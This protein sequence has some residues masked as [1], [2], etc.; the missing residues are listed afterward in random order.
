MNIDINGRNAS[1]EV[2]PG[3]ML[4]DALI[5]ARVVNI[6]EPSD[7]SVSIG[8]TDHTDPIIQAGIL[9]VFEE[10]IAYRSIITDDDEE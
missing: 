7:A 1:I 8:C 9:S 2:P 3:F 4:M 6:N 10:H 5:V